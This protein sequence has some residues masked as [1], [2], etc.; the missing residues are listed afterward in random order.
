MADTK[1][2]ISLDPQDVIQSL[3]RISQE[4]KAT[5]E[6]LED[7]LGKN[8]S[9]SISDLKN[10]AENGT[11]Q[12]TKLFSNMGTRIR[13]DLKTAFDVSSVLAGA[14]FAKQIGEGVKS[15][16][17]MERA[18]DRLG[19][20]LNLT[21]RQMDD[22]KRS[23]GQAVSSAGVDLKDVNP[24][25]MEAAG[26]GGVKDPE[27]L[28]LIARS[29]AES[30]QIDPTLDTASVTDNIAEI[31]QRQGIKMTGANFG[32]TMDAINSATANGGFHNAGD[33]ASMISK[34]AQY[35]TTNGM[36]TRQL[37]GLATVGSQG[38]DASRSLLNQI[39]SEGGKTGG[40]ERINALFGQEVFKNGQLDPA[41]LAKV[42][43]KQFGRES[44]FGD[45]TGLGG[46]NGGDLKMLVDTFK[47]NMGS[48]K[49]VVDGTNETAEQFDKATQS[50]AAQTELFKKRLNN[51]GREIGDSLVETITGLYRGDGSKA[52]SGLSHGLSA[53]S[54]NKGDLAVAGGLTLLTGIIAGN[55]VRGLM[56]SA[57]AAA[58]GDQRVYVTNAGEI[59]GPIGGGITALGSVLPLAIAGAIG[60]GLGYAAVQGLDAVTDG[61]YSK[62]V[63]A[64]GSWLADKLGD[65]DAL[66]SEMKQDTKNYQ[67]Y[68]Q[69]HADK[70]MTAQEYYKW[71]HKAMVDAHRD[72]D[73]NKRPQ[74][75]RTNGA[76]NGRG[77]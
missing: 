3:K 7:S 66:T 29:L 69:S 8:A 51:T 11:N 59:S 41:A 20:R 5:S 31:L 47:N 70:P 49:T 62:T 53:I 34:L 73:A 17:D 67:K 22:F 16:F 74:L 18:F 52:A 72:V 61:K 26:R 44:I 32:S 14:N 12:I 60:A 58:N 75:I 21:G 33:A 1:I 56:G 77:G 48:F 36:S 2:S 64:G 43:T 39:L 23:A 50:W 46:A 9:G 19:V 54:E 28:T 71:T 55:G 4:A 6:Q 65:S 13:E 15:V 38:G 37:A 40:S 45:A 24:G 27:Q 10:A 42:N 68:S 76:V 30:R 35:S 63:G 57:A 25:L